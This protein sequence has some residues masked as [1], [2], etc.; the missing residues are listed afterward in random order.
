MEPSNTSNLSIVKPATK[1]G[2]SYLTQAIGSIHGRTFGAIKTGLNTLTDPNK[3]L[4]EKAFGATQLGSG[5]VVTAVGVSG[6]YLSATALSPVIKSLTMS[7]GGQGDFGEPSRNLGSG[8]H[9]SSLTCWDPERSYDVMVRQCDDTQPQNDREWRS[10]WAIDEWLT[11]LIESKTGQESPKC[12]SRLS[13][14]YTAFQICLKQRFWDEATGTC[15]KGIDWSNEILQCY[16]RNDEY[17]SASGNT[18][19]LPLFALSALI[20]LFAGRNAV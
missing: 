12:A 17:S 15:F 7:G 1:Q 20:T 5:L 8:N 10:L 9:Y 3:T 4:T 19:S 13:H 11:R 2:P 18:P 14:D 6:L 16:L